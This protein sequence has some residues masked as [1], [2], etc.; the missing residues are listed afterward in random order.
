MQYSNPDNISSAEKI[1]LAKARAEFK[2]LWPISGWLCTRSILYFF[3]NN[4]VL[5]KKGSI[6]YTRHVLDVQ[7]NYK[8]LENLGEKK[9]KIILTHVSNHKESVRIVASGLEYPI[10]CLQN[11]AY[12]V[13]SINTTWDSEGELS[14]S[15]NTDAESIL[16]QQSINPLTWQGITQDTSKRKGPKGS[17]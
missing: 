16:G 11:F 6:K 13:P 15:R 12:F 3:I 5:L 4:N 7:K 2:G 1:E 8:N 9:K 17:E 10:R 14:K